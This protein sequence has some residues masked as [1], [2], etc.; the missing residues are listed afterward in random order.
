MA[1]GTFLI[2]PSKHGGANVSFTL[3]VQY[4]NRVFHVPIRSRTD[5]KMALGSEKIE[6]NVSI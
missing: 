1:N 3:S 6:E 5:G 4:N 2:R